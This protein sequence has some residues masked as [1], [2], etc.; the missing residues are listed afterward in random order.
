MH[1]FDG[2]W[3][4]YEGAWPGMTARLWGR[5]GS[6]F[7]AVHIDTK[8]PAEAGLKILAPRV[9]LEPTTTRLT[10]AGSTIE[11]SRNCQI[12]FGCLLASNKIYYT[13]G[14]NRCKPQ[15]ENFLLCFAP[16]P[17]DARHCHGHQMDMRHRMQFGVMRYSR[18]TPIAVRVQ[19]SRPLNVVRDTRKEDIARLPRVLVGCS[20]RV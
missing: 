13:D 11:L 16:P 15:F 1:A 17:S 10:A 6:S 8:R 3:P 19:W 7:G 2:A 4:G 12:A 14:G 9:G 18:R 20:C 5:G